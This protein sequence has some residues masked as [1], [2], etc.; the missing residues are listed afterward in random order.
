MLNKIKEHEN[1]DLKTMPILTSCQ[2]I[3]A[4]AVVDYDRYK[5]KTI[6]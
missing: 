5:F 1:D 6:I 4:P 3:K 2:G